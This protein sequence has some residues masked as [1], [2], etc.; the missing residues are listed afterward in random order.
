[1]AADPKGY[2]KN[3]SEKSFWAKVKETAGSVP[4]VVDAL[5]MYYCMMDDDTPL[6]VKASI[7]AA[8][9]YFISPIDVIPDIL[10]P[11][12]YTDDAAVVAST[13]ALVKSY[14][15][16]IHYKQARAFLNDE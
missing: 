15:K 8:L 7:L 4:F 6:H 11:L 16:S 1:M 14:V 13:L 10:I 5:A 3:F 9:G 12:G 2:E